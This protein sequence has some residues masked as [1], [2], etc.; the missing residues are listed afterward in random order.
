MTHVSNVQSFEKLLGICTGLGGSYNPGKQNL[1]IENLN[2][3][4]KLA[5]DK[6]L[7]V[8]I[9]KTNHEQAQNAR[10]IAF[11]ELRSLVSRIMFELRSSGAQPQAIADATVMT[12]RIRGYGKAQKPV[13][14]LKEGAVTEPEAGSRKRNSADFG[15]TAAYFEKLLQ[16]LGSEPMYQPMKPELQMETLKAT[17]IKLR[18]VN[19][20]V[21]AA[22][23][24]WSN[25]RHER[26]RFMYLGPES[27]HGTAMDMKQQVQS[28]YGYNSETGALVRKIRFTKL[29]N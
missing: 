1:R 24:A 9:V 12:R 13:A 18:S 14:S 19:A 23:A 8:S 5:Q 15:N 20:A 6:L 25:A 16:T 3:T 22:Y 27:L 10:E 28:S 7:Q 4:L 17:L 11:I 21:V 26:T 29:I 2:A